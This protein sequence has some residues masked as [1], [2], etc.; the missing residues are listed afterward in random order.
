MGEK[1]TE[2]MADL[3]TRA[4]LKSRFVENAIP[5]ADDFAALID[6][7][8]NQAD[9]RI[10]I[11]PGALAV[12]AIVSKTAGGDLSL[13]GSGS[14]SVRVN[15]AL[16]VTGT[17][18]ANGPL[19]VTG[20]MAVDTITSRTAGGD[21]TLSGHGTGVV[22]VDD[23]L[24]V[25]GALNAKE[26]LKVRGALDVELGTRTNAADGTSHPAG[27]PL[28]VSGVSSAAGAEFRSADG[29]T[30]ISISDTTIQAVGAATNA[31]LIVRPRG[32][33]TLTIERTGDDPR[34]QYADLAKV[35]SQYISLPTIPVGV[36]NNG[37]T[38]QAWVYFNTLD[39][40]AR[41]IDI[42]D[43]A[44]KNNLFVAVDD[45]SSLVV[46]AYNGATRVAELSAVNVLSP[47]RWTHV[48]VTIKSDGA[49]EIFVNGAK[50][51]S[52]VGAT[53]TNALPA[54]ARTLNALGKSNVS[55]DPYLN[56][57]LAEVSLW[58]TAVSAPT[59]VPLKGNESGLVGYWKLHDGAADACT[60]PVKI[61][62][63]TLKN[64]ASFQE[65][66]IGRVP[67]EAPAMKVAGEMTVEGPMA[68]GGA[69]KVGS[70]FAASSPEHPVRMI[71]GFV[72]ASANIIA[73]KG[74]TMS[75]ENTGTYRVNF[76]TPFLAKPCVVVTIQ[77]AGSPA[78]NAVLSEHG[79]ATCVILTGNS[80]GVKD[81]RSFSFIAI[82]P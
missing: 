8:M 11:T 63:A 42:A 16:T 59:M 30:G 74:F 17:L 70:N 25:T 27:R 34:R 13:S 51:A 5:T 44:T 46:H 62:D 31:D 15:D 20:Q 39:R 45:F 10:D 23:P 47:R 53:S 35:N 58:Q 79:E 72:D 18:N 66:E 28:Y 4:E 33:G 37:F 78:D 61:G 24:T 22:R 71:W 21:L 32:T 55:N 80:G 19:T 81:N 41:I 82:G 1:A 65:F 38:I 40:W 77:I 73:G 54:V 9:D 57:K 49:I 2:I 12:D 6:A 75:R 60:N 68:V 29:A 50:K 56:G 52:K 3:K 36:F 14:G 69:L 43:G 26:G 48:A 76:T 64:G 67:W 7:G